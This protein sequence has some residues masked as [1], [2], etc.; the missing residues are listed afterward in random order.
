M[1]F[2]DAIRSGFENYG[3]FEGRA[4]RAAYWWW[5]LFAIL[6]NVAGG[7]LDAIL[8]TN[9]VR[10]LVAVALFVPGLSVAVRRLH[11]IDRSGWWIF[12]ILIPLIGFIV[13]LIWYLREGDPADNQYGPP[14]VTGAPA[15]GTA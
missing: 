8:G 1:T 15:A 4:S 9:F 2:T 3:K 12:L 6:A 5:F 7:I 14:P 10:I 11:D 13:L